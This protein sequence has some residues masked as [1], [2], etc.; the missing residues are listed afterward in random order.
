M[1]A[2]TTKRAILLA[3][4]TASIA[5]NTATIA[6]A[7]IVSTN[8]LPATPELRAVD[9]GQ[10][11]ELRGATAGEL[12]EL[13]AGAGLELVAPR[14]GRASGQAVVRGAKLASV[15]ATVAGLNLP[16]QVRWLTGAT[17]ADTFVPQ[18]VEQQTQPF[19]VTVNVPADARPGKY[20]GT[21]NVSADGWRGS[22]PVTVDVLPWVLPPAKD[23]QVLTGFHHSPDTI[24]LHYKVDPWSD[25][26]LK[27]LE[28]SLRLL[29][30]L[31]TKSTMIYLVAEGLMYERF[32]M[33]RVRADGTLDFTPVDKYLDLWEKVGGP[34]ANLTLY[35]WC[36]NDGIGKPRSADR[37]FRVTR[38][39]TDGKLENFDA[40]G[41]GKPGSVEFWQPI[42]TGIRDRLAKRGWQRTEVLLGIPY[43]TRPSEEEMEFFAKVAPGWRWRVYTHGFNIPLPQADGKLVLPDGGD[44]G[45]LEGIEPVGFGQMGGKF[46]GV[47]K[48]AKMKR[49][50]P[51]TI[52]CRIHYYPPT[53]P[54]VIRDAPVT[55]VLRG[56]QGLSA[57]G[58]D[59][60]EMKLPGVRFTGGNDSHSDLCISGGAT[61]RHGVIMN[62]TQPGPNGAEPGPRF[63]LIREGLQV[64]E[65]LVRARAA[66]QTEPVRV[67]EQFIEDRTSNAYGFTPNGKILDETPTTYLWHMWYD[68]EGLAKFLREKR[69][70]HPQ[71][72]LVLMACS[73]ERYTDRISPLGTACAGADAVVFTDF[74]KPLSDFDGVIAKLKSGL[75]ATVPY[76]VVRDRQQALAR[77]R[78]WAGPTGVVVV[79]GDG[80]NQTNNS[81]PLV[82]RERGQELWNAAVRELYKAAAET[83]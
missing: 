27:L 30:D 11:I 41:Y 44:V 29:A 63:E 50:Y 82:V 64:A 17:V 5:L 72:R 54:W 19:W 73:S 33:V 62:I 6:R 74:T 20:A 8:N 16:V 39:T 40:P 76:E 45:W 43:D 4:F 77:A 2:N 52:I 15:T 24:A 83:K 68:A 3:L 22:L 48:G 58:L 18:P 36:N 66:G 13:P 32:S 79:G 81:Q 67:F 25:Q 26:H 57:L 70:A 10:I 35:L 38:V 80:G 46:P 7:Q 1:Q 49:N 65:A 69:A 34:P 28:P 14:G 31:G 55:T 56:V 75:P 47:I 12:P 61:P 51:F 53:R 9:V 59:Y 23:W 71:A 78:A 37:P 60:W 21:V 42:F